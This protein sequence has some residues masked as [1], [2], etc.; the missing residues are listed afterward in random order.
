MPTK[1]NSLWLN[2]RLLIALHSPSVLCET[3]LRVCPPEKRRDSDPVL[4]RAVRSLQSGLLGKNREKRASF[5]YFGGKNRGI[6]L[7]LRLAGGESGNL[8]SPLVQTLCIQ[9]TAANRSPYRH[10]RSITS[11]TVVT[12]KTLINPHRPDCSMDGMD[13]PVTPQTSSWISKNPA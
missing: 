7:Q 10:L 3:G 8:S 1:V 9:R 5:A 2:P 4:S 13:F 12:E 11:G 6:S